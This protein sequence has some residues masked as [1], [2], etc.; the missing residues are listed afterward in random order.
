MNLENTIDK[1]IAYGIRDSWS[2]KRTTVVRVV[3]RVETLRICDL[4]GAR[5]VRLHRGVGSYTDAA[6]AVA[7]AQARAAAENVPYVGYKADSL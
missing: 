1:T 3:E 6:R 7:V 2:G 4:V 5:R